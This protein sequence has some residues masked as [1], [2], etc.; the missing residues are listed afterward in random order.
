MGSWH[1]RL[2]LSATADNLSHGF[3][4]P[5][6][7]AADDSRTIS[8]QTSNNSWKAMEGADT[9]GGQHGSKCR[10]EQFESGLD[11]AVTES[12]YSVGALLTACLDSL[13]TLITNFSLAG[14]PCQFA[15]VS[16]RY[17]L[18]TKFLPN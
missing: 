18:R 17:A 3:L 6:V 10:S 4:L 7:V 9:R 16:W 12:S 13:V 1:I 2:Q 8:A 5:H 15:L 11:V 14:P